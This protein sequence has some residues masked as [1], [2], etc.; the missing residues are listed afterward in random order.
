MAGFDNYDQWKTASPYDEDAYLGDAPD[1][2]DYMKKLTIDGDGSHRGLSDWY[3]EVEKVITEALAAGQLFTT[4]WYGSKHEIASACITYDGTELILEASVSN[5]FD[6]EGTG[7]RKIPFT[8]DLDTI[9]AAIDE[10]W[11]EAEDDQAAHDCV[12]MWRIIVDNMWVETYL[13]DCGCIDDEVPPGD[14]YHQWGF[15][16]NYEIPEEIKIEITNRILAG[17]EDAFTV[18]EFTI[19]HE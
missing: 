17:D 1:P 15:Q 12:R 3:P 2:R 5:D 18:G 10:A 9:R 7:S 19:D 13:Q 11:Q 14:Y 16:D 8:T 6:A 4:G